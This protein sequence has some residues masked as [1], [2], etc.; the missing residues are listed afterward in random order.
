[1]KIKINVDFGNIVASGDDEEELKME[2]ARECF[3]NLKNTVNTI[4]LDDF[5]EYC[6]EF[7]KL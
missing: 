6:C 7:E 5:K 4:T 3:R 1:M 2:L